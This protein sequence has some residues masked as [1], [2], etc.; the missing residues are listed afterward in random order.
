VSSAPL[1]AL[2][3][4]A[5][6]ALPAAADDA[7]AWAGVWIGP[8][9]TLELAPAPFVDDVARLRAELPARS[10][11]D[12]F[13][14]IGR[15][16]L[17]SNNTWIHNVEALA[18]GP[19]RCT[20]LVHPD[21]AARLGLVEGGLARVR[22]RVGEVEVPVALDP[23]ILPGVVSLPHGFGHAAPGALLSVAARRPGVNSNLLTDEA[24]VDLPSGNAVL[25]GIPVTVEVVPA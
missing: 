5:A 9:L 8:E 17:R 14:L 22:S 11:R 25:S 19:E 24:D 12:G 16:H 20:L 7:A 6:A 3:L 4:A 1:A 13:V 10:R 2:A 23:G 18:K 15:R 21:D